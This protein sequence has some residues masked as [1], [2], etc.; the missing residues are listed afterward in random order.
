MTATKKTRI[1]H[2][3]RQG[4]IGGGETHVLDL[5]HQLNRDKFESVILAFTPGPMVDQLK[6]EGFTVYVV[7]T[8]R[9]FNWK[10]WPAVTQILTDE[11]IDLVHAH[12]T[13]ANSNTFYSAKKLN[14]PLVYTVHGWSFHPDQSMPVKFIRAQSER[15]LVSKADHTICVSQSNLADG[16]KRFPISRGSVIVNGI[17]QNKFNPDQTFP[18]FRKEINIDN[19]VVL[20]GYIARITVQKDPFTFLRAIALTPEVI[21]FVIIGDG[22]LKPEMLRLAG[23]L[24]LTDRI[25]FLD[26][27]SDIPSILNAID[28]FCLPSLWEGLP[29]ALLEAMAMRKA[30]VATAIDGTR[31]LVR[32]MENGVLV[33]VSESSKLA[34]AIT[35]LAS[36]RNLRERL[37]EQAY[38]TIKDNFGVEEMALKIENVYDKVLGLK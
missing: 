23:E 16:K 6:S 18:D 32:Q 29:I 9:P 25:V 10:A 4:K 37:G 1:L 33:P 17:N 24:G 26:F 34:D 31:D 3:I 27:R 38:R 36:D 20:V 30:I 12:G 22:E 2:A 7:P 35:T 13:R 15:L 19:S 28:I 5:V 8:E 14:I 21:K 11:N